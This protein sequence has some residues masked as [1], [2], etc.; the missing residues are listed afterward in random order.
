MKKKLIL[1]ISI[2]LLILSA[3]APRVG[4]SSYEFEGNVNEVINFIQDIAVD[5]QASSGHD[6]FRVVEITNDTIKVQS[7]STSIFDTVLGNATVE[8]RFTMRQDAN[9]VQMAVQ[10]CCGEYGEISEERFLA[11]LDQTFNRARVR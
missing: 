9:V 4:Q 1:G 7:K 5:I 10:N 2:S 8:V 6:F 3:C 11:K